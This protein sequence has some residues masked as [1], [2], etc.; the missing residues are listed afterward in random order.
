MV[1]HVIESPPCRFAD[2]PRVVRVLACDRSDRAAHVP[3]R[4]SVV[5][6]LLGD[7]LGSEKPCL[8]NMLC[9]I[10]PNSVHWHETKMTLEYAR[11]TARLEEEK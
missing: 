8:T 1:C 11:R 6:Q 7:V 3:Y 10:S 9:C 4:D 5:T 2:T